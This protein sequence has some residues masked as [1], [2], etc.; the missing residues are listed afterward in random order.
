MTTHM[1]TSAPIGYQQFLASLADTICIPPEE[2][3]ENDNPFDAGLDSLRLMVL[4][5]N[6]RT[7]GVDVTFVELAER[8]DIKAWWALISSRA[9]ISQG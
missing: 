9:G 7:I 6:W 4:V 1:D 5:E 3:D 2:L 8:P